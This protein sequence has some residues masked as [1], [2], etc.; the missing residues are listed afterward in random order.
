M[1]IDL[2]NFGFINR[3][4]NSRIFRPLLLL[5]SLAF[6]VVI[7]IAGLFGSPVGDRNASIVMVWILWFFLLLVV[8]LPLGGRIWCMACPL[9]APAE[10]VSRKA[11]VRKTDG[12]L[13]L[14]FKWPKGLDNIWLQNFA[15]LSVA[16]FSPLILTRPDATAYAL[17]LFVFLALIID[18]SFK[19]GRPGKVFCRYLCPLGGFI[20]VCATLGAL[21]IRP[22]DRDTCRTCKRKTC[23]KG[24]ER[25]YGCP[26]LLYPGG[27]E[28]NTY[29]GLCLE[30]IKSCDH[31]NMTL[32]TQ[33]FGRDLLKRKRLDEAF[34]GFIILG[35]AMVY[36]AAYFGWWPRLKET[37]NFSDDIFLSSAIYWDR[38]A[39]FGA[40]LIGVCIVALPSLHLG[41]A[42]LSKKMAKDKMPLKKIFVDYAY[43]MIPLGFMAWMGFA[44]GTAMING[45]HIV[46]VISD[47]LGWGWD[48]FGTANYPWRPYYSGLVPYVQLVTF[49]IGGI[50]A[51]AVGWRI[52][53]ENFKERA[54]KAAVPMTLFFGLITSMLVFIFVMP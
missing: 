44:I 31:S 48:I 38:V 36:S 17:L 35:S 19:K 2:L 54:F 30:C 47:P 7:I 32:I 21:A 51:T 20:G 13:N 52:S 29:C 5:I 27:L 15:F 24:N 39:L 12:T 9:P 4:A 42:W 14:G 8:L 40:F 10:W 28:K 46:S 26:W 1:G 6:F 3:L 16:I 50:L 34:M 45:S 18:L 33:G 11:I 22:R 49:L 41:F 23:I 43:C 25:G 37:I 53:V